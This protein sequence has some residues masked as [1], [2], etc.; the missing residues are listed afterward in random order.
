MRKFL[1]LL[2][3][4]LV[5]GTSLPARAYEYVF[6]MSKAIVDNTTPGTKVITLKQTTSTGRSLFFEIKYNT[7]EECSACEVV[8]GKLAVKSGVQ[9]TF[10]CADRLNEVMLGTIPSDAGDQDYQ[11]GNEVT[12]IL[13][14]YGI[15]NSDNVFIAGRSNQFNAGSSNFSCNIYKTW[16]GDV[17]TWYVGPTVVVRTEPISSEELTHADHNVYGQYHTI[18]DDLVGVDVVEVGPRLVT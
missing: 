11:F 7:V 15:G 9:F 1:F 4:C 12:G 16:D 5:L 14:Y 18:T 10:R 6:D 8:N 17:K 2:A 13:D 3:A